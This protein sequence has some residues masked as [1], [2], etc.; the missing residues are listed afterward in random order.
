MIGVHGTWLAGRQEPDLRGVTAAARRGGTFSYYLP[1]RLAEHD[2][3][4]WLE[5]DV[6]EAA[7][8]VSGHVTTLSAQV[9]EATRQGIY[10]LL[11]RSESIASSRIEQVNASSRDVSYAQ[12]GEQLAHLRNDHAL[13][14]SRNVAATR[15]AI[16]QLAARD[17]WTVEDVERVHAALGVVGAAA[18]LREVDVWIGGRDKLRADYVAPPPGEVRDLVED[19]LRYLDGSGEHPLLLAAVAHAQF[20]SIHPFEDGNGRAGRALVHAVLER[21]GVVRSG[22][23]PVSTVIRSR[24][25]EYIQRLSAVRTDDP[26]RAVEA[27]NAWVRFFVEVAEEAGSTLQ[28]IQEEVRTLDAG[29]AEKAAG[30]R[31]DSSARRLLP[32][33]REQPVVTAAFVADRLGVSRV[34]AHRAV[35]TLVARGILTPGTGKHRRSETFQA[36]D[37]LQLVDRES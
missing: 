25:R 28:R 24:E 8:E 27:L 32:V 22:L 11:L 2:A 33:L 31:A 16:E 4:S 1:A 23:L 14:V 34:A 29:L 36:D 21:G 30:L 9:D 12:L 5:R 6:R 3:G 17:E 15:A 18:G 13:S 37:V 35:D 26:D 20:E 19:L 10:H 7:L